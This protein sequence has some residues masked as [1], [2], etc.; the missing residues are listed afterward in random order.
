MELKKP[1]A[2]RADYRRRDH[3]PRLPHMVRNDPTWQIV[4]NWEPRRECRTRRLEGLPGDLSA[5]DRRQG[6]A[7]RNRVAVNLS[8]IHANK[9][10]DE[11][12][13]VSPYLSSLS[14][15]CGYELCPVYG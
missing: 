4:I 7:T 12:R 3:R 1:V 13:F 2:K 5:R 11:N 6:T 10:R 8:R 14:P 9:L 15:A